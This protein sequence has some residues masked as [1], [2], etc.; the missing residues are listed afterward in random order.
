[1][2]DRRSDAWIIAII[3][4]AMSRIPAISSAGLTDTANHWV[5]MP[6]SLLVRGVA[7]LALSCCCKRRDAAVPVANMRRQPASQG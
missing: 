3:L 1:V 5:Q 6:L 4:V 7:V 2:A